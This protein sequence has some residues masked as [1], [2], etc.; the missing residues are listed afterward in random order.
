MVTCTVRQLRNKIDYEMRLLDPVRS[1]DEFRAAYEDRGTSARDDVPG[2]GWLSIN[3]RI[4]KVR[5]AHT[6]SP[7]PRAESRSPATS[8]P[9][10]RSGPTS[11]STCSR[12]RATP[13][14]CRSTPDRSST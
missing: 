5:L 11:R 13:R 1:E 10:T 8:A 7:S 4:D 14:R 9:S 12:A 3:N 6:G 2:M